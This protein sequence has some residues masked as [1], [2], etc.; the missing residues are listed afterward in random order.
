M[1]GGRGW[2]QGH[3]RGGD[4][5]TATHTFAS[6]AGQPSGA[7]LTTGSSLS[8]LASGAGGALDTSGTLG[9]EARR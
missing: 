5:D 7:G 6:R 8:F 4:R 2:G 1:G 9:K 3:G